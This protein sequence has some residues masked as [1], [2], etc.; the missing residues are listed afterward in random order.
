MNEQITLSQYDSGIEIQV[1]F[2]NIKKVPINITGCNVEIVFVYP[3]STK[4]RKNA[5]LIDEVTGQCGYVL[6][7][8]FTNQSGLYSSYWSATDE[9]GFITAQ[10][11][12][13]YYVV[14]Y[15]GGNTT[16]V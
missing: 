1:Q 4:V 10:E 2:I 5:Y 12:L 9:N 11:A 6:T 8:E 3:D 14:D 16:I 7:N 15:N 13:Y